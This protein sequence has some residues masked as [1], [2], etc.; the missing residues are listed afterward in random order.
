MIEFKTGNIF[1]EP[2]DGLVNPVNCVG[3]MGRGLAAQFKKLYP[4]NFN[5]YAQA[6]KDKQV[7]PG[8]MFLVKV[9]DS[10]NPRFI[11]NFPTKRHW[12]EN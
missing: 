6:C 7:Q 4:Q 11:I 5:D 9:S 12:K 8:K 3:V 1:D 2:A 10:T